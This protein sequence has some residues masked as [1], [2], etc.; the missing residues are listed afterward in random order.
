MNQYFDYNE[1]LA[2]KDALFTPLHGVR[3][4]GGLFRKVFENNIGFIRRLDMDR[5]RYWFDVKKGFTPR[6]ERYPGHFEDNLKGQTASQY[7]MG[8]GNVLR[9]EECEPLRQGVNEIIDFIEDG[10]ED[11]GFIMPVDKRNFAFREYPHYVRI[12]L[13]YGL[14]AAARGGNEKAFRLLRNWQDWFNHCPDLPVIK[15]LELAFQGVV[16][17][18]SVFMTEI[19]KDEDMEITRKYYEE[20][21][22]LA[23]FI[24]HDPNAVQTRRQHGKEPHPHGSELEGFEGYLDLYRYYGAPYLLNAVMGCWDLYKRDWQHPGGG[25]VM[26]EFAENAKPG[27][28]YFLKENRYNELCCTS[29]WLHI[30]QRLHRLF[31]DEE[32]YTF[33]VEQSIYNIAI[34]DQNGDEDIRYFAILDEHKPQPQRLN[35]CCS[36]VGTRIFGSLPEYLFT[37]TKDTLSCDLYAPAVLT[38]QTDEQEIT[39][40]E[41]TNFPYDGAISLKFDMEKAQNVKLRLRMPHYVAGPVSVCVNGKEVAQGKPG[42]Y[43]A[44]EREMKPGDVVSYCFALQWQCVKYHG[45]EEVG[46]YD[47]Y[48][49]LYGPLLMAVVGQRNYDHGSVIPGNGTDLPGKLEPTGEPLHFR[50]PGTEYTVMPYFEIQREEFTCFPMFRQDY[51]KDG[52]LW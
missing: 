12:W 42:S 9:W 5:M 32:K 48:S 49:F 33:E 14:I 38:W 23:E 22:R 40:T 51:D 18:T 2:V 36:G 50:I 15:Y 21:W 4:T 45:D 25:I 16:A 8:A 3:L 46:G 31:P 17:S 26:C 11:D 44:L 10:A 13:S 29:F 28:N 39:V 43:L 30:N 1:R 35:H 20:S 41:E 19:G 34:A 7:L 24:A 47:R 6:A 27:A 37:M 52:R